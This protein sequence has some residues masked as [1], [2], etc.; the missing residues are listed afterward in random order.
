MLLFVEGCRP[1]AVQDTVSGDST[2][3]CA[4][5]ACQTVLLLSMHLAAVL[6]VCCDSLLFCL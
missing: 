6:L 2:T 3:C 5:L 4:V 1:V